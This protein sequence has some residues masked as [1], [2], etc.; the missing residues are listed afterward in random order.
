LDEERLFEILRELGLSRRESEIYLFLWKKGPQK[1]H[2][3]AAALDMDRAQTYRSLTSLQEKG[4]V[5]VTIEAPTR[6]AAT[7]IQPLIESLI[8]TKKT[9]VTNLEREKTDLINYFQTVD[10]TQT[11]EQ[12]PLARFQ[13]IVGKHGIYARIAQMAGEAKKEILALTTGIGLIQEDLAGVLDETVEKAQEKKDVQFH[14]LTNIS[15]ENLSIMKR[16]AKKPAPKKKPNIEWRHSDLATGFSQRFVIKDE[17]E[18]LLYLT[19][20]DKLSTRQE[21]TGLLIT[22]RMFVSALRA[23]FMEVWR[24]AV[25]LEERVRELE[26]GAPAEETIIIRDADDTEARM[27]QVLETTTSQVTLISSPVSIN[28][29]LKNDPFRKHRQRGVK[30]AVMTSI[31]LDNLEAAKKLSELYEVKHVSIGYLTMMLADGRDLFIFK[32]PPLEDASES[33]FYLRNV[34]YTNDRMFVE[35]TSELLN[36]I[37]K[38]GTLISEIG[39]SPMGTSV[40][41]VSSSDSVL[42]VADK[43]LKNNVNSILV[44]KGGEVVGIVDQRDILKKVVMGGKDP[45]NTCA[46]DIMSTPVLT[47]DSDQSLVEALRVMRQKCIPRLAVVRNGNLVAVLT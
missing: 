1:A 19:A 22:S 2:S 26:T 29:L 32:A 42:K 15:K 7:P 13:V 45:K 20:G 40:T 17:E 47:V 28:R 31:D 24:N 8:K 41:E 35:R 9:E 46:S 33:P 11:D 21:D 44:S 25:E 3:A 30:F 27:E 38:R 43:L 14:M 16:F 37:W 12:F 18:A 23:Y 36:D 6:Y 5:Q 10:R 34:F 39:G 4:I